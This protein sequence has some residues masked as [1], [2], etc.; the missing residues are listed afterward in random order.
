MILFSVHSINGQEI[1]TIDFNNIK[2]DV[3]WYINISEKRE[4]ASDTNNVYLLSISENKIKKEFNF[5]LTYIFQKMSFESEEIDGFNQYLMIDENLVIVRYDETKNQYFEIKN[6]TLNPVKDPKIIFDKL[7]DEEW[8]G[9]ST[10]YIVS[11]NYMKDK[12]PII[13]KEYYLNWYDIPSD[14]QIFTPPKI[15][16]N[17]ILVREKG[18]W[19]KKPKAIDKRDF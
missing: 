11:Y 10:W 3:E 14:K 17:F 5:T 1:E 19:V 8:V 9:S 7:S 4:V 18:K 12:S 13:T 16:N 15:D 6:L 2:K